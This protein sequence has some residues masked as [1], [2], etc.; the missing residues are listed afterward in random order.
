VSCHLFPLRSIRTTK[1][2]ETCTHTH[3][4]ARTHTSHERGLDSTT[5][6]SKLSKTAQPTWRATTAAPVY[7]TQS[8]VIRIATTSLCRRIWIIPDDVA[9]WSK[10]G[11]LPVHSNTVCAYSN[12]SRDVLEVLLEVLVSI[13]Y[14]TAVR[15]SLDLTPASTL[16]LFTLTFRKSLQ[17]RRSRR[18]WI[19]RRQRRRRIRNLKL[20]LMSVRFACTYVFYR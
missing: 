11:I 17:N 18:I 10:E 20:T 19:P 4:R 15:R 3:T 9:V 8:S 1:Q 12:P 13:Y 6:A 14:F 5:A 16:T 7:N 2:K